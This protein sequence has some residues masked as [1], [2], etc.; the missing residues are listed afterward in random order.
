VPSVTELV[1]RDVTL[2]SPQGIDALAPGPTWSVLA[3]RLSTLLGAP[4]ERGASL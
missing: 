3:H 4:V 2:V 1:Q